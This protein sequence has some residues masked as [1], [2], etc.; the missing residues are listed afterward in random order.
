MQIGFTSLVKVS[1]VLFLPRGLGYNPLPSLFQ[2]PGAAYI[3]LVHGLF[4]HTYSYGGSIFKLLHPSASAVTLLSWL[5]R[6][7]WVPPNKSGLSLHSRSVIILQSAFCHK[8]VTNSW[9]S[10]GKNTG[11]VVTPSSGES[12]R[13]RDRTCVFYVS[14]I[15]RWFLYH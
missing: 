7:H 13:P 5:L 10:P 15:G 8:K 6:S 12:S 9:D 2:S 11:C 4:L 3:F 14:C 1:T